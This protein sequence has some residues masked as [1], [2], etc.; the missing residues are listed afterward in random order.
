HTEAD[1]YDYQNTVFGSYRTKKVEDETPKDVAVMY[2]V[3][4]KG[5]EPAPVAS[6]SGSG[7]SAR[8][9]FRSSTELVKQKR[10]QER[11]KTIVNKMTRKGGRIPLNQYTF[12]CLLGIVGSLVALLQDHIID[13]LWQGR[14]ALYQLSDSLGI[15]F[16]IWTIWCVA[17]ALTAAIV[18]EHGAPQARGSG[19]PEMKTIIA[20]AELMKY[21]SWRTF[22]SKMVG[23]VCV[24]ASGLSV[25]K[26][27]PFV[28]MCSI[29]ANQLMAI[30]NF[31]DWSYRAAV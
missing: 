29:L 6:S 12:L 26:E 22:F 17:F 25:G 9:K 27:G 2:D 16:L 8:N 20:G 31:G 4:F 23:L 28:H 3:L 7:Q 14:T 19:I 10:A 18:V 15:Q 30:P 13:W 1:G 24:V 11:H 5:H 21:L